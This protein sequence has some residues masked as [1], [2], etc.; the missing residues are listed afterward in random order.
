MANFVV[1]LTNND[2]YSSAPVYKQYRYE[3]YDRHFPAYATASVTFAPPAV[4]RYVIVH[5]NYTTNNAMCMT[6]VKVFGRGMLY[7]SKL[8]AQ[9]HSTPAVVY[10]YFLI[11]VFLGCVASR[12][13][14]GWWL[15]PSN[16]TRITYECAVGHG[17]RDMI[18]VAFHMHACMR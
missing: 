11:F 12:P 1:G 15:I 9:N 3:Q 8:N 2:P 16:S 18:A 4:F 17:H 7:P 5:Q 10:L 13:V 14:T 6:E